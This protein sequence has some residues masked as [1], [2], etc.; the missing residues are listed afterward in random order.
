MLLVFPWHRQ[1]EKYARTRQFLSLPLYDGALEF[2]MRRCAPRLDP[3]PGF[4]HS[5]ILVL[6]AHGQSHNSVVYFWLCRF[7]Y[8]YQKFR[9]FQ[10]GPK[11]SAVWELNLKARGHHADI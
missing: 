3:L 2:P 1:N 7:H 4:P 5:L 9:K 11:W 10:R 8:D 6:R